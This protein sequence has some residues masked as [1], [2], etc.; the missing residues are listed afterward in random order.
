MEILVKTFTRHRD[1]ADKLYMVDWTAGDIVAIKPDG[2][3]SN[4]K[5]L[6]YKRMGIVLY[7]P[8][9][10]PKNI[11]DYV[12][13]LW[14]AKALTHHE[15][16]MV[17]RSKYVVDL[18]S[19][20]TDT[21]LKDVFNHDL[22]C[23][24][25][26][27]KIS[28]LDLLKHRDTRSNIL[29]PYD[30]SGTFYS[31]SVDVGPNGH[32]DA[33]DF[34]E[35][36]SNIGTL[37]G[38]LTGNADEGFSETTAITVAGVSTTA[39]NIL[40]FKTSGNGRHD[41]SWDSS[42]Q[43]LEVTNG[44]GLNV[45]ENYFRA[46]GLQIKLT[47]ST[48]NYQA[49]EFSTVTGTADLRVGNCIL[50]ASITGGEASGVEY[51][52][53]DTDPDIYVYNTIFHDFNNSSSDEGT[54]QYGGDMHIYNCTFYDCYTAM[55]IS[56]GTGSGVAKNNVI[57]GATTEFSGTWTKSNNASDSGSEAQTLVDTSTYADEF[58]DA[59]NGD[60]SLVSSSV[61]IDNGTDDPDSWGGYSDDI[62]GTSRSTWDIGAFEY[63][64]AGTTYVLPNRSPFKPVSMFNPYSGVFPTQEGET[65]EPPSGV[66]IFRRRIEG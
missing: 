10:V 50:T 14:D 5:H 34:Y 43:R 47:V 16:I 46:D 38:A 57:A 33:N 22:L 39:T 7:A 65:P 49:I 64:S 44:D 37:T 9:A 53:G 51:W 1:S 2:Y 18:E 63:V 48:G 4:N 26:D 62:I 12:G 55:M 31:G 61:C 20:L 25:I 15:K 23:A 27:P 35:F 8:G 45:D 13:T 32:S 6:A 19:V 52:N 36:E 28:Y 59:G 24:K 3:Y 29:T 17:G 40:T 21:Q 30:K 56:F 41:G 54:K 42:A 66:V 58:T 11:D 60:F